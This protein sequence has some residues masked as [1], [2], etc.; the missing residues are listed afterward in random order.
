MQ[1]TIGYI[2]KWT[3]IPYN[4]PAI[5]RCFLTK[6][7][8]VNNIKTVIMISDDP[9]VERFITNGFIVQNIKTKI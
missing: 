4:K 7:Y 1:K 5:T 9:L 3:T 6:K 8:M 2:L